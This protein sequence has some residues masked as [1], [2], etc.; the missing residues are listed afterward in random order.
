MD[1]STQ[2]EKSKQ[3]SMMTKTTLKFRPAPFLATLFPVF[4][5]A[6]LPESYGVCASRKKNEVFLMS[7]M[8]LFPKGPIG[9]LLWASCTG[10][11][12][13]LLSIQAASRKMLH[14]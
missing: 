6:T 10:K 12:L 3:R 2:Y 5:L 4:L 11:T 1:S 7:Q 14:L 13:F 8:Q 9:L